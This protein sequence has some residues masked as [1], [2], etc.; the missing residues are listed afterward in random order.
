MMPPRMVAVTAS[1]SFP[2]IPPQSFLGYDVAHP[3][4]K[5][6]DVV[7]LAGPAQTPPGVSLFA[8]VR[9]AGLVGVCI[10]NKTGEPVSVP[11]AAY[12]LTI[13]SS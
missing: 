10:R 13:V 7:M 1:L 8:F 4:A 12:R 5:P 9:E 3:T 2:A 6:G 11:E